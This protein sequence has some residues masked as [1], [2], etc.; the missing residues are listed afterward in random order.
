MIFHQRVVVKMDVETG[1]EDSHGNPV[2][3]HVE[4]SVPAEVIPLDTD[5]V[6]DGTRA[7]V[8]S[9]YRVILKAAVDI[10]ANIGDGLVIGWGPF[11]INPLYSSSGLRVDGTVERHYLRGRLHHYEAITKSVVG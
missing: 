2:V 1:E 11:P 8:V 6:L 3:S 10:P 5:Q 7:A 9:R 4:Q